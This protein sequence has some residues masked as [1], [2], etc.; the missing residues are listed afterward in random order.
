M[1]VEERETVVKAMVSR[2]L[3]CRMRTAWARSSLRSERMM[4]KPSQSEPA[5]GA[6][7]CDGTQPWIWSRIRRA[8]ALLM[9]CLGSLR[10]ISVI[11]GPFR[12]TISVHWLS[13]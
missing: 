11:L 2:L 4:L 9:A 12:S 1:I 6:R 3:Q 7:K 13:G 8:D 10:M 5:P